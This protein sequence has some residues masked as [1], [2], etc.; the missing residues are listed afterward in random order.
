MTQDCFHERYD[1]ET[2]CSQIEREGCQRCQKKVYQCR[3]QF[4]W[5]Y[6]VMLLQ[7]TLV[8]IGFQQGISRVEMF[9]VYKLSHHKFFCMT[10]FPLSLPVHTKLS[11]KQHDYL[12]VAQSAAYYC[13]QSQYLLPQNKMV[14]RKIIALGTVLTKEVSCINFL[15]VRLLKEYTDSICSWPVKI[16]TVDA[17]CSNLTLMTITQ[18]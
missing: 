6:Q 7:W 8:F 15:W 10:D 1:V 2:M 14:V 16:V 4:F 17:E 18:N 11:P 3:R 5:H 9:C 12:I 13:Y